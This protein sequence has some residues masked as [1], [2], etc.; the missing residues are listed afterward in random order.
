MRCE[1]GILCFMLAP[2]G[3]LKH[4]RFIPMKDAS[5][6]TLVADGR[7][8]YIVKKRFHQH[9]NQHVFH[10]VTDV[11]STILALNIGRDGSLSPSASEKIE[12]KRN[13]GQL[14]ADPKGR[15]LFAYTNS[16]QVISYGIGRQGK[17]RRLRTNTIEGGTFDEVLDFDGLEMTGASNDGSMSIDPSGQYAFLTHTN[18]FVD[19]SETTTIAY[20]IG[21]RG[22]LKQSKCVQQDRTSAPMRFA[23]PETSTLMKLRRRADFAH[24]HIGPWFAFDK[25]SS[26]TDI[27]QVAWIDGYRRLVYSFVE[28]ST[29]DKRFS[30]PMP[31]NSINLVVRHAGEKGKLAV[32]C[33]IG[34]IKSKRQPEMFLSTHG[35]YLYGIT[36]DKTS[37][38][39][40]F[41][42]GKNGTLHY[43]SSLVLDK[44]VEDVVVCT[45]GR[46]R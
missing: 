38:I 6:L 32:C 40:T 35:D 5:I 28:T 31:H 22:S 33:Q 19:H 21:D 10:T 41:Y 7:R 26:S 34:D 44:L 39:H 23:L 17:L 1:G 2:D 13:V 11:R 20:V 3:S 30:I 24:E 42:V 14:V 25:P 29:M 27:E 18:G 9:F 8:L 12:L 16:G 45:I 37:T 46:Q 43:R 4:N 36:T 15:Y